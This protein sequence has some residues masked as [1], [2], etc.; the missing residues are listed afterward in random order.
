MTWGSSLHGGDSSSVCD[1]LRNVKQIQSSDAAFGAILGDGSVIFWGG[2]QPIPSAEGPPLP[3]EGFAAKGK[4]KGL[5]KPAKGLHKGPPL[6]AA[7]GAAKGQEKGGAG[8][9]TKGS[10]KGTAQEPAVVAQE[11]S[12]TAAK[13]QD[14]GGDARA[15]KGSG[16]GKGQEPSGVA[17]GKG[18]TIHSRPWR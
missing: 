9:V 16:K 12:A 17:S 8:T 2:K 13:G 18:I 14:K 6:P 15:P 4:G 11:P 5:G 3:W 1:Q 10:C 7:T